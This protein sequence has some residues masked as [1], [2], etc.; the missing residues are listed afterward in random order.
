LGELC[1]I[2]M[3]GF[4]LTKFLVSRSGIS[5]HFTDHL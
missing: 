5:H 4:P 2:A 1:K 3:L